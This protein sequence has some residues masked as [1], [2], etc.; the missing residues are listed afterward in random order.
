[1]LTYLYTRNRYSPEERKR[2]EDLGMLDRSPDLKE[3]VASSRL[4][5]HIQVDESLKLSAKTV[6]DL[7]RYIERRGEEST[8][9][10]YPTREQVI[11]RTAFADLQRSQFTGTVLALLG[12][13]VAYRFIRRKTNLFDHGGNK[14]LLNFA[15]ILGGTG[16]FWL[17]TGGAYNKYQGVSSHINKRMTEDFHKMMDLRNEKEPELRVIN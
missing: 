5:E 2:L 12:T 1:M 3:F 4:P 14:S 16:V 13:V 6:H 8:D 17:T 9:F 7:N 10:Q 15:A 11:A